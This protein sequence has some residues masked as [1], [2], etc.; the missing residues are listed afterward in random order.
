MKWRLEYRRPSRIAAMVILE[1]LP[2]QAG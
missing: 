2:R 1:E